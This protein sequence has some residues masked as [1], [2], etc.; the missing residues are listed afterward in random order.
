MPF[1]IAEALS[2]MD[3]THA[4]EYRENAARYRQSLR[5]FIVTASRRWEAFRKE[6]GF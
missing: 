4:D 1:V 6:A 5:R 3:P 2:K